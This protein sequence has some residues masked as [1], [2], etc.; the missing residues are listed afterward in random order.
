MS[1]ANVLRERLEQDD[2]VV[3][4]LSTYPR[5]QTQQ[6]DSSGWTARFRRSVMTRSRMIL[7]ALAALGRHTN[8]QKEE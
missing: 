5:M 4:R 7:T 8:E 1:F 3:L 6:P 2:G